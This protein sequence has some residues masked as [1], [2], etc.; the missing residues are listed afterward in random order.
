MTTC[1]VGVGVCTVSSFLSC[2]LP[3]PASLGPLIFCRMSVSYFPFYFACLFSY[4][5]SSLCVYCVQLSEVS[6]W[7]TEN[8]QHGSGRK[9]HFSQADHGGKEPSSRRAV[10]V[11]E[12]RR[13]VSPSHL[14]AA[15]MWHHP[16]VLAFHGNQS[17][18]WAW[19]DFSACRGELLHH[20]NPITGI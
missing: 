3:D 16:P 13:L 19:K 9:Q 11:T 7:K 4:T 20:F 5:W 17:H 12:G 18:D 2:A 8:L 10:M 6:G 1:L 14:Q 15:G